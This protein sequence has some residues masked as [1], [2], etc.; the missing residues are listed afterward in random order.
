MSRELTVVVAFRSERPKGLAGRR[1]VAVLVTGSGCLD[2]PR[3]GGRL[4][5]PGA[6]PVV[7][8]GS[9]GALARGLA[10]GS[11]VLVERVVGEDGSRCDADDTLLAELARA[12]RGAGLTLP[13][14]RAA[15][16]TRV[17]DAAAGRERLAR[18]TGAEVVDM[19]SAEVAAAC[20]LA[21][22]PW[23]GLRFV[24][25][26]PGL[27][28]DWLHELLGEWPLR[29]PTAALVGRRLAR[30]PRHALR[31]LRLARWTAAGRRSLGSVLRAWQDL[32]VGESGLG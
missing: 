20:A 32:P 26:T 29:D 8:A 6:G 5:L 11:L 10:P 17:E 15:A 25:D 1:G 7:V 23:A 30:R 9:C 4:L 19:E 24:T 3:E 27:P 2:A 21:G 28:L 22:R 12:A 16:A 18:A 14:V 13:R 31:L